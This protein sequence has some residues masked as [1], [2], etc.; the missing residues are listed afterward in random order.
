[1]F[2]CPAVIGLDYHLTFSTVNRGFPTIV[3]PATGCQEVS[4]LGP[5]RWVARTPSFWRA[6]GKAMGLAKATYSTF[7]DDGCGYC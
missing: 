1:M 5:T 6:L 7:S 4:G 2:H 3:V